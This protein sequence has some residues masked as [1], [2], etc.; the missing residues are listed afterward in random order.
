METES[1]PPTSL[2]SEIVGTVVTEPVDAPMDV[3][4]A[5]EKLW[6]DTEG[7]EGFNGLTWD[8]SGKAHRPDGSFATKAEIEAGHVIADETKDALAE[9]VAT[10]V[11]ADEVEPV[12]D[13]PV[14]EEVPEFKVV[15]KG[16][17]DRGEEDIE[18]ILPDAESV[19][20]YNR[21]INDGLRKKDYEAKMQTVSAKEAEV[22]EFFTA[23]EH[24][25]IGTMLNAIP[26]DASLSVAR[27][28]VAEH[29][30]ALFPEL[31][32]F[33]QDPTRVRETRLDAREQSMQADRQARSALDASRKANAIMSAT[34]ALIPETVAPAIR[35]RFIEDAERDLIKLA[36]TGVAIGPETVAR[37]LQDRIQMYGFAQ[38]PVKQSKP[39]VVKRVGS[40]SPKATPSVAQAKQAQ[41]RTKSVIQAQKTAA[42]IPPAGRG[43]AVVRKPL[44]TGKE[45]IEEATALLMR[46]GY[47][48]PTSS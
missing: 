15:L 11:P 46:Q 30:D 1:V 3:A 33:S 41:T 8:E 43:A 44:L 38:D 26:R 14:V 28:L 21:A 10:E 9:A 13:E 19:E 16:H 40:D 22:S 45:T 39:V 32:Q 29:W 25:P 18:L 12:V 42:A 4:A 6:K 7:S 24:N 35:Q 2:T 34:E 36:Q 17:P 37:Q 47:E 48:F 5:T 27:A 31:Q 23:L 20:R